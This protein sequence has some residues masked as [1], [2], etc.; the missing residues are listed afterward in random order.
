MDSGLNV[1]NCSSNEVVMQKKNKAKNQKKGR[2]C[3]SLKTNLDFCGRL[4]FLGK[5]T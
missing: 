3:Q 5:A 4:I 2:T 1:N